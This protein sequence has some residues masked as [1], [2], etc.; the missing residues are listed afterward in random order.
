MGSLVE[1]EGA[2]IASRVG[3]KDQFCKPLSDYQGTQ[4]ELGLS[5]FFFFLKEEEELEKKEREKKSL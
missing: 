5:L 2:R 3:K 1:Q 4:R